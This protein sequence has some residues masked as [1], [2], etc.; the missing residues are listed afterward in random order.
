MKNLNHLIIYLIF[1]LLS[2]SK[3]EDAQLT[4]VIETGKMTKQLV[5]NNTN[6][7]YIIYVPENFTGTSSLP[8]LLS[9][10]GLSSNMNFNYDYT[11]FDELAERENFI[12]VHPNGIDNRWTVSATNNP[13][14]DFIEALL[15]QL[16]NDYN[17]ASNR[18]YSTGMSNGGNFSFTL[19]CGLNDRIA[20][21]ASVTGLM[22]Q[23][24]IG[25][26]IPSRP[27]AVLHIHGT[28]DLIANYAFV[29][30]GLDFWT[31]H[32]NTNDFPIISDIPNIDSGDG[33]TVK[34]F[35]Y[36]NGNSN[37]EVQHLKITGGGHEWPGFSGNMDINASDE[38]W[39]FVKNFDLSGKI[40]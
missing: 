10:H 1:I 27:L 14:I 15:D 36:L 38:V 19:A 8:L 13:D 7:E 40:E 17:I 25:N 32:N 18:I 22:L 26:C 11:N 4:P 29:Q 9:F 35:E 31:D 16:E 21:I 20:A 34:R 28:E 33:S 23:M 3:D 30:G 6:R 5:V 12:V 37:V 2:C 39:N 24:A